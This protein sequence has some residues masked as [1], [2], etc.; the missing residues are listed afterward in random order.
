MIP[1]SKLIK[2]E[3]VVRDM[4]LPDEVKLTKKSLLRW[5]ALSLGLISP[6]ESRQ[7]LLDVLDALVYF[8]AKKESPTTTELLERLKKTSKEKFH[9]KTLYYHLLKM[10]EAGLVSRSKG[11]YSLG[12]GEWKPLPELFR[13][14]Y[15]HRADKAFRNIEQALDKLQD[16]YTL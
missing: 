8:H 3:I 6:N 1:E 11:K 10:K 5:V 4:S 2:S 16:S 7:I 14:L 9:E 13:E 15:I 12:D